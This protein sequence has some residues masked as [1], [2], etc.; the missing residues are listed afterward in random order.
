MSKSISAPARQQSGGVPAGIGRRLR[1]RLAHRSFRILCAAAA[2]L[3]SG[4]LL[5]MLFFMFRTG[6]LTF[7]SVSLREFFL[8]AEWEPENDKYGALVFIAGTFMVTALTLA[9]A[10]PISILAALFLAELAP[11]RLARVIRPILDLLVGIPSVVYGYMGLTLL[12]PALR[13][14]TGSNLGD[15]VL[16]A[17]LVLAIMILP[18]ITR[19]SDDAIRTVPRKYIQGSYALGATRFQTVTGVILPAASRGIVQACILGMA[20]AIGETM[21]VVMVI[22]NTPQLADSLL[23]PTSVLTSNIVMQMPNVPFDSTWNNALYMMGFLL[24]AISLLMIAVV[25]LLQKKG[26]N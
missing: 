23:K 14:V 7:Q 19:I 8:S 11:S 16:A 3:V 6:V 26:E 1:L 25:R 15:G 10:V 21:A 24:L 9:I 13:T 18:T 22:G 5:T 17:S 4:V 12:I 2:V 20:R